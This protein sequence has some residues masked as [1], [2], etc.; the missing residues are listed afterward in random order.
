[1]ALQFHPDKCGAPGADEAFKVIAQAFSVLSDSNKRAHYDR[2]GVD[3]G[4]RG[5]GRGGTYGFGGGSGGPMYESEI[6]PEELFNMFF[7]EMG[8]SKSLFFP[9]FLA[10]LIIIIFSMIVG[11]IFFYFLPLYFYVISKTRQKKRS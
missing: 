6:S 7:G 11:I 10:P 1:L 3:P 8:G 2:Y 9:L 5:M 4:D